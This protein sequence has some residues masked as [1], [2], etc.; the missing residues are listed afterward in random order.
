MVS[1][2]P[3]TKTPVSNVKLLVE[4]EEEKERFKRGECKKVFRDFY[5]K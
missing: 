3:D 1:L 4:T 2:D 5:K